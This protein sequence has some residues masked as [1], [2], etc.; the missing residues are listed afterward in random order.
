MSY[1]FK[2][3]AHSL[4]K[5]IESECNDI[6]W[7]NYEKNNL[8]LWQPKP[9]PKHEGWPDNIDPAGLLDFVM[10]P[11]AEDGMDM[12]IAAEITRYYDIFPEK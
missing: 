9:I 1:D 8:F 6:L 5:E 10:P 7:H 12:F 2:P 3:L 11:E 4:E